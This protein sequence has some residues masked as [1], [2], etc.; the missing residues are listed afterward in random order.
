MIT[1][2]W[3]VETA[4]RNFLLIKG[5]SVNQDGNMHDM[6]SIEMGYFISRERAAY[7]ISEWIIR[8]REF[9]KKQ[10]VQVIPEMKNSEFTKMVL[11]HLNEKKADVRFVTLRN[12]Y[13]VSGVNPDD[14]KKEISEKHGWNEYIEHIR[15]A[16]YT[17][18][19]VIE[20][21]RRI[22]LIK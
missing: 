15:D 5:I 11:Y 9:Y 8:L 13:N 1:V 4:E 19:E 20:L 6:P 7:I 17:A 3:Q 16:F 2:T 10:K 21:Q 18:L 22:A 12:L 14:L